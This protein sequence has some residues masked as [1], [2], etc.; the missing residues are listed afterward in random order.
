MAAYHRAGLPWEALRSKPHQKTVPCKK[1]RQCWGYG[2]LPL[3]RAPVGGLAIKTRSNNQTMPGAP[4][5]LGLWG[6]T[7]GPGSRGRPCDQNPIKEPNHARS[8]VSAG[9]MAAYHRAGLPW[10]ALRSKP[11]QTTT[12]CQEPRQCWGYGVLPPGWVPMGGLAI[13]PRSNNHTM[14]GAPSVLGLW[15]LTTGPGSRGRPC[16]QNPIK[17]PHHARSRVSAGVMGS[18]HRA[19]LPWGARD[20]NPI[21][22]SHHARSRV[23]AGF[24]GSYHRAGLPWEGLRS[25]PDQ[26]IT[27]CRKPR[28]CWGYGGLPPGKA[29]IKGLVIK[30]RSKLFSRPP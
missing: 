1:P 4:S 12:P 16:D 20:Q 18:Y 8:R 7:T 3:G 23:S 29:P 26:T 22:Q 21:K 9:V 13:K 19:G 27:P 24:I 30:T 11:D 25:K 17:E 6:L 5:V 10:E 28:Q 2:V 15:G 14:P